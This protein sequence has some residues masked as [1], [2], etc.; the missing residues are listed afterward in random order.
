MTFTL[1]VRNQGVGK[2]DAFM[3]SV[4]LDQDSCA[5]WNLRFGNGIE[6]GDIVTCSF[7]WTATPD[8]HTFR[9]VADADSEVAASNEVNNQGTSLMSCVEPLPSLRKRL[10]LSARSGPAL[11]T[12]SRKELLIVL[13]LAKLLQDLPGS[14]GALD[15]VGTDH[16]RHPAQ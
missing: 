9:S 1:A 10:G 3:V 5:K 11:A 6:V 12:Q 2:A 4:F 16:A 8:A 7:E 15:G 14:L 13:G